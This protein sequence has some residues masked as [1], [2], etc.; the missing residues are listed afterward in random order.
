MT[1]SQKLRILEE[2]DYY[3]ISEEEYITAEAALED[4]EAQDLCVLFN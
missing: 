4:L 3:P 2:E 1:E